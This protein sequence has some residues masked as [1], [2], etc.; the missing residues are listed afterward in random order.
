[1]KMHINGG[2]VMKILYDPPRI[3]KEYE[4]YKTNVKKYGKN[5]AEELEMMLGALLSAD[6][7][8]D[9]FNTP[10]YKMHMLHG[11]YHGL[12]SLS[13]DNKKTKWR[14]LAACVDTNDKNCKPSGE[15]KEFLKNIKA[16]R[17]GKV[18]DHYE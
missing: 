17:L 3:Q 16:L 6:N 11:N 14:V 2:F 7:A 1:M 15:E 9:I 8:L 10:H 18:S 12:Y 13:P 4:D 5:F